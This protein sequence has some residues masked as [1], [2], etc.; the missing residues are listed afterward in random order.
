MLKIKRLYSEPSLFEPIDFFNGFNLIL[1]ETT[2]DSVK[3]NGV[4]KSLCIEFINYALLK[5]HGKSRVSKIPKNDLP[6]GFEICLD[7]EVDDKKITI[8]RNVFKEDFPQLYVNGKL[9]PVANKSQVLEY[10]TSLTF[11]SIS[12]NESPSFRSILGPLIRDEKSEF[13]SIIKC[14]DTDK[15]IPPDYEPHLYLLGINP[16]P[17]NQANHLSRDLEKIRAAK[18]KVKESVEALTG[19]NI[20]EAKADLND[21]KNQAEKTQKDIDRLENIEGYDIVKSEIIALED[22][23]E[24]KRAR[25]EVLKSEISKIQLFKGDNYIDENEV[26]DLYNQFK[27]G[28]G[29]LIKK[30]LSEVSAF[31][32]KI[33]D[34]QRSLINERKE[35]VTKEIGALDEELKTLDN[36]YKEKV[37]LLDQEGLLKSLKKTIAIHQRKMEDYSSLNSFLEAFSNHEQERK[38]KDIER[39]NQ[40]HLLDTYVIEAKDSVESIESLILEM[41]EYV[42]G[43]QQCSFD[44]EVK[45]NKEIVKFDLRIYDDGSHSIDREK[46]FFYDYALLTSPSTEGRHPGLLIH[47]NIFEV[48]R[49]TL[50]KNLD[51]ISSTLGSLANK[52][53][54]LTLNKDMLS[55]ED[56]LTLKLN[57]SNHVRAT[58]TKNKRFLNIHYQESL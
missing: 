37:S 7:F 31:K 46:V 45:D 55:P 38:D 18:S 24:D 28:L 10:L 9:K 5:D 1:G 6:E 48:D 23:I 26:A 44:V 50:I 54:I 34:F 21:L 39:K 8:R 4:G 58:F 53:Y 56:L 43:N 22:E 52:Q 35:N 36:R 19:K 20:S 11:G 42:Y 57:M 25:Q 51:Y 27:D 17:Y 3:T 14:F 40:I 33:D 15:R 29:D 41:H 47:D 2:D 32:K 30:E 16:A 49:D 12:T 13:K